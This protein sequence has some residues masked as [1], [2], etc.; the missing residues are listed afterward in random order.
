MRLEDLC[1]GDEI[2]TTAN[3]EGE[4]KPLVGRV[5]VVEILP[6]H[7]C[8]PCV[9]VRDDEGLVMLLF[10]HTIPLGLVRDAFSL[11]FL[12]SGPPG[13]ASEKDV[14]RSRAAAVAKKAEADTAKKQADDAA[15][16]LSALQSQLR[17]QQ[18]AIEAFAESASPGSA[19]RKAAETSIAEISKRIS[20][21]DP[22]IEG[23]DSPA[24]E[25]MLLRF[26]ETE[27][28]R[29]R[30]GPGLPPRL[31]PRLE[32]RRKAIIQGAMAKANREAFERLASADD[33]FGR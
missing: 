12:A 31:P 4:T 23:S 29:I 24:F 9:C 32:E 1:P 13:C 21:I 17:A 6:N 5:V 18:A 20:G 19:E 30:R 15:D 7:R 2:M 16:R 33:C 28:P 14:E 27:T 10:E 25:G 3:K 11:I 26:R 8:G 22:A